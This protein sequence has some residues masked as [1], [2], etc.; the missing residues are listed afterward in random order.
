MSHVLASNVENLV[1]D[2]LNGGSST[3]TLIGGSGDDVYVVAQ[4]GDTVTEFDGE[5]VDL[6]QASATHTL[7]AFVEHLMQT[8]AG[9]IHGNRQCVGQPAD[10]QHW[11][12]YPH[13]SRR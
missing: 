12:Q 10:R 9:N 6:V 7:S 4:A 11:Q 13:G 5:G 3:D 2:T 1:H 8:G